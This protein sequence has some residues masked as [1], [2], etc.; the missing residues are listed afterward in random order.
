[1][2]P[3]RHFRSFQKIDFETLDKLDRK[4]PFKMVNRAKRSVLNCRD[5]VPMLYKWNDLPA[6]CISAILY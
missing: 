6:T 1:M 3:G 4:K 2:R 5:H